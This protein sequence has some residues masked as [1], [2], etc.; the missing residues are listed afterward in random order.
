MIVPL[1]VVALWAT[2]ITCLSKFIPN[3]NLG[4]NSIL[5]TVTGFTVSLGLSFRSSTAYERY[6]DGRKAWEDVQETC[7]TLSRVYWIHTKESADD[8][9]LRKKQI[10]QKLTALNLLIAFAVSLKHRLRFEPYTDY[11][12]LTDLIDHLDTFAKNATGDDVYKPRDPGF[13]KSIGAHLGLSFATSNPRKIIKRAQSPL[14]NLPL[15]ILCYLSA[16]TDEVV[17]EGRLPIPMTQTIA[18]K[19]PPRT[20]ILEMPVLT[21]SH[22]QRNVAA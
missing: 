10:L 18:C 2:L 13:F 4:V 22:R 19:C 14:G 8:P 12:D 1:L 20:D 9:D 3:V 16:Y 7:Q 15:E 11:E 5:L 17:G 6:N 21:L